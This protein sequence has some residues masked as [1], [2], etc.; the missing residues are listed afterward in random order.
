MFMMFGRAA[1]CAGA[2]LTLF[3]GLAACGRQTVDAAAQP[4]EI[5]T[6]MRPESPNDYMRT[7]RQAYDVCARVRAMQNLPPPPPLVALP[8][9]FVI[10]RS[11]YLS[12]GRAYLIRHEEFNVVMEAADCKTRIDSAVTESVVRDGQV[13]AQRRE[14]DGHTEVDEPMPLSEPSVDGS[15]FTEKRT[16]G[17][18]AMR[19]APAALR[20]DIALDECVADTGTG[21][22]LDGLRYP[23]VLHA[24][25]VVPVTNTVVLTEP[26]KVQIG[27]PV[28]QERIALSG[29]K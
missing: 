11:T 7:Y 27:K 18:I 6:Q 14:L 23:I 4:Y 1:R 10:K 15:S 9:N 29:A 28:P 12:S 8:A 24:R 19:C 26:V 5:V 22:L 16:V 2:A 13:R 17:G 3:A 25:G 20:T 21:V